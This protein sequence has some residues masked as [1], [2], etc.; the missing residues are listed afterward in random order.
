MASCGFVS[1][2]FVSGGG[3]FQNKGSYLCFFMPGVLEEGL[4]FRL[5]SD[6]SRWGFCSGV[7]LVSAT[8]KKRQ[9]YLN[10]Y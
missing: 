10:N 6:S 9:R 1:W 5:G 4:S 7:W 3:G 8:K 2:R